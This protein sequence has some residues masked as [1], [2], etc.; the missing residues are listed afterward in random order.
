MCARTMTGSSSISR[1]RRSASPASSSRPNMGR[2]SRL[3]IRD[4]DGRHERRDLRDVADLH[5]HQAR[6]RADSRRQGRRGQFLRQLRR[7]DHAGHLRA[8][9]RRRRATRGSRFRSTISTCRPLPPI[10]NDTGSAGG[11]VGP[12]AVSLDVGFDAGTGKIKE[13]RVPRRHDRHR[14]SDG[15]RAMC[16]SPATSWRSTGSPTPAPSRWPKSTL[17][18]GGTTFKMSGVFVLGYD[19]LY[20]PIVAISM[21]AATSKCPT[22]DRRDGAHLRYGQL[23]RAG[24]RRSTARSG[25]DQV[26]LARADGARLEGQG[27]IDTVR[28]GVG[29]DMSVAGTGF[30]VDDIKRI[31]PPMA[32]SGEARDWFVKN[33]IAGKIESANTQGRVPGRHAAAQRRRQAACR[34]MRVF[35]ELV[36]DGVRVNALDGMPPIAIQGKT[37]LQVHDTEVTMA[38]DGGVIQ[39]AERQHFGRQCGAR[40]DVRDAGRKHRRDFG[41][42]DGRHPGDRRDRRAVPARD[43]RPDEHADRPQH[44]DRRL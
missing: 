37:R 5:R 7:H 15:R 32:G 14:S 36:A 3:V 12:T 22:R 16:R 38:A 30:T 2:F 41:R 1:R 6:H 20:G 31:W 17:N 19:E 44:A 26:I 11:I 23:S 13:R 27:R 8:G 40:H 4:G 10:V 18:V 29:V 25:I 33:V 9:D 35:M 28:K 34:R 24:R 42:P 39:T 43:G 21:T